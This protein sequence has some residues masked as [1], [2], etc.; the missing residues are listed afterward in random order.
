MTA[1]RVTCFSLLLVLAGCS[2][3]TEDT[4]MAPKVAMTVTTAQ[5]QTHR[6]S[7]LVEAQ[8]AIAPWQEAII[9]A[10]VGGL[11]LLELNVEVGDEVKKGQILARFDTRI[12]KAELAQA[13]ANLAQATA[14]AVQANATRDRNARM[15][16]RGA[17]SEQEQQLSQTQAEMAEAQRQMAQA[18]L[19]AQEIRLQD[20]EVRAVDDGV[21]SARSATLGQVAQP[22][23]ELFRLIRQQRLEWQVELNSQQVGQIEVGQQAT[24]SLP[25]GSTVGGVVRQLAPSLNDGTRLGLAYVDLK[26]GSDARAGMYVSGLLHLGEGQSLMVPAEAVVL[27]DGRG[28]VFRVDD[29]DR[30][31]QVPVQT[32]RRQG[33]LIEVLQGLTA[34]DRVAVRGAGFLVDGDRIKRVEDAEPIAQAS[35]VN[36][37]GVAQ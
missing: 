26:T 30:V 28:S 2:P 9:S 22:G 19:A 24:L 37:A 25:D 4:P 17:L 18:Q 6:L 16:G 13:R 10:R 11:T 23:T 20:C 27:R 8:G 5:A 21:I 1:V 7:R 29:E 34:G 35:S 33:L 36:T 12:V 14:N 3:Q 31:S 15:Q 32:G